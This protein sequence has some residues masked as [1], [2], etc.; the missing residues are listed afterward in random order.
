M[1]EFFKYT[2]ASMIGTLLSLTLLVTVSLGGL[3]LLAVSIASASKDSGP[4]VQDKTVLVLDLKDTIRDTKPNS[5]PREAFSAALSEDQIQILTLRNV[6]ASIDHAS[7]NENIVGLLI[8]GTNMG[9]ATDSANLKE[10]REALQRFKDA[11]KPIIAYDTDWSEREYYLGSIANEI[12]MNPNGFLEF[13]GLSAETPFVTGALE[14]LG[15]GVQVAK[16]GKY[17][18]AVEPFTLKGLSPENRQQLQQLLTGIWGDYLQTIAQTRNLDP[19]ALQAIADQ[20]GL[21]L[22]N[23]AVENKLINGTAYYDQ[24]LGKLKQLTGEKPTSTT[25]RTI[26][27]ADYGRTTA[28]EKALI[29]NAKSKNQVAIVYAEGDIVD[30]AGNN[31]NIG[32]DRLA[33]QLR[34]LRENEQVKAI[35]LRI[36]SG[37]GSATASEIMAREITLIK[38]AKKPFIVSMGSVAA[39][40][41]YLISMNADQIWAQPNTITGSIGVFGVL[42][43]LQKLAND[44]GVNW[45]TVKTGQLADL[46]TI[47][48]PKNPQEL[49]LFQRN[50]E[51]V[52]DR[53]IS[54]VAKSRNLPK[55][56]VNEIAQGR[57]WTGADAKQ[58]GLVD[59]LGGMNSAI[60]AVVKQASLGDDWQIV[61]YP[62][63]QTWEEKLF[64]RLAG[65]ATH[66]TQTPDLFS[67]ELEALQKQL[68]AIQQLNDPQGIYTRLPFYINF[69][70]N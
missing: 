28:V 49:A 30:G 70:G 9:S 60:Q 21:L 16:V 39:S 55:E 43:N 42:F 68:K 27:L 7:R 25:V 37:G 35:V 18:S 4:K 57:I 13:N 34:E 67:Q 45:E 44:N 66:F 31:Q 23:E 2:F 48:R 69:D 11:K 65:G 8:K 62:K 20:K 52:Y 10:V 53:F 50:V 24:V 12:F 6:V 19:Q 56:K 54:N 63:R 5:S 33:K 58:I 29:G 64:E 36:N 41:G 32:G 59:E 51:I 3:A 22:A 46:G 40:G 15:V 14:K 47:S 17:K 26:S 61:E 1:R 38:A